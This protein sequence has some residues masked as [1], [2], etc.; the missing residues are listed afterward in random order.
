MELDWL[1][2]FAALAEHGNFSRAAQARHVTQPA[3]SRRI[4]ALEDWVGTPL[5]CRGQQGVTLTP[6]GEQFR[7]GAE[8]MVRR[9][10][11]LRSEARETAGKEATTLRF[12]ATHALS[13]TFF[14]QWIRGFE[15][16]AALATIRLIS[17]HLHACEELMLHGQAQFLLCHHHGDAPERF[18]SGQF[19]SIVVGADVLVP[20][21]GPDAAGRA[22]WRLPGTREAPAHYLDYSPES[23]LGR[24]IAARREHD[25]R[26]LALEVVFTS[27][28]AAALLSM[29]RDGRGIAWLPRSLAGDDMAASRLLRAGD[30]SFDIP[31]DIRLVRPQALQSAAAEE[32]WES[33]SRAVVAC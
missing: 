3:F 17:D 16:S 30:E 24:I 29:A 10:H 22:R 4:R 28:L 25:P 7:P 5:F 15:P 14:P 13:F 9:V 33:A 26:A 23:G 21:S 8:E 31:L 27:H 20:L 12:A 1:E 18:P 19:R 32:L 11:Q 6:A 2:D